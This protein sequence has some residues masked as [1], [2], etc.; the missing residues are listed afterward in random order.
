M[1]HVVFVHFF[2]KFFLDSK[3]VTISM[4]TIEV[5]IDYELPSGEKKEV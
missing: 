2:G 3:M 1:N 4:E 5:S